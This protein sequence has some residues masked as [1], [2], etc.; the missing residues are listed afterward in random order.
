M[1]IHKNNYSVV[2][3]KGLE[4]ERCQ[5]KLIN[6]VKFIQT[7]TSRDVVDILCDMFGFC[8]SFPPPIIISPSLMTWMTR[9]TTM[10]TAYHPNAGTYHIMKWTRTTGR[11]LLKHRMMKSTKAAVAF[12][13]FV[14]YFL[15]FSNDSNSQP[16]P[17]T[18]GQ[19]WPH[20]TTSG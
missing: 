15:I 10:F 2:N 11:D 5:G 12:F 19:Q 14:I 9:T 17:T 7:L 18:T 1:S 16:H 8:S 3:I 6:F 4:V 13:L 20:C